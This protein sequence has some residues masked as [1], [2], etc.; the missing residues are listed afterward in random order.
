MSVAQWSVLAAVGQS[1]LTEMWDLVSN[2]EKFVPHSESFV[3]SPLPFLPHRAVVRAAGVLKHFVND[4]VLPTI[5][6]LITVREHV[7]L[8]LD[9]WVP[10]FIPQASS[11]D[12][13]FTQPPIRL[14]ALSLLPNLVSLFFTY[15]GCLKDLEETWSLILLLQR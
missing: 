6:L 5:S 13:H 10:E 1:F 4:R 2:R 3:R 12:S 8:D 11:L 7:S 15:K 14:Q 9:V